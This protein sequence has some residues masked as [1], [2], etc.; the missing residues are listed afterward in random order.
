MSCKAEWVLQKGWVVT[1]HNVPAG[2]D[3]CIYCGLP[4]EDLEWFLAK[5]TVLFEVELGAQR[6]GE[7]Q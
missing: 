4:K 1:G 5:T 7:G 2:S 6:R 3:R